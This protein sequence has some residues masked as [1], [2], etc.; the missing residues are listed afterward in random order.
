MDE[1]LWWPA[2]HPALAVWREADGSLCWRSNPAAERWGARQGVGEAHWRRW[3]QACADAAAEPGA[4]G[5]ALELPDSPAL[6]ATLCMPG[7]AVLAWLEPAADAQARHEL[8]RLALAVQAAGLG[9][10][11][12]DL[13]GRTLYWNEAMY[14]L[15]GLDP[16]DP[17]PVWQLSRLSNHPEDQRVLDAL[18]RRHVEHGEPYALQLR[19]RWPDGSEH[20]LATRGCALETGP[21]QPRRMVGI[22]ADITDHLRAQAAELE[23]ERAEQASRAKS[24]LL[25]RVSHELRTPLNAVLGFAQ[26]LQAPG[27][28]ALSA[29]QQAWVRHIGDA[30]QHLLALIDDLLEL[31]R[32][33]GEPPA[34][35]P[36]ALAPLVQEALQWSA[37]QARQA[38]V[39]VQ[40]ELPRERVLGDARRVRQVL[41]NL[42]SNAI[43]YNRPGGEVR[44]S[45]CRSADGALAG[46][47]VADTGPGLTPEQLQQ[48]GEPFNRLGAE[49]SGIPGTGIG[50][51]ISQELLQRMG[52]RLEV[53]SIPGEGSRFSLW[54]PAAP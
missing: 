22:N 48:L 21:G 16:S 30:G 40:A 1:A 18:P 26:L 42:L 11:E 36:V 25:A 20:G 17:R 39:R 12:S 47:R 4:V 43:K 44:L 32:S 24:A 49:R 8:D 14:R 46:L 15:R 41:L 3:A 33:D 34:R 35:E 37:A 53:Q 9:V 51:A 54:L 50:L 29:A 13:D 6:T 28:D 2:P 19:V 38:G 7:D 5:R 27:Q 31:A 52:G 10:W 45:G 23:R